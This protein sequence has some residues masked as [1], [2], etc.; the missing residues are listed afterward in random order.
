MTKISGTLHEDL[1]TFILLTAI[2]N[3]VRHVNNTKGSH[4]CVSVV[5]HNGLRF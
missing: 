2:G 1:S 5:T 3:I 4:C